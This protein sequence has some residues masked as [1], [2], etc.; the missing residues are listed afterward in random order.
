MPEGIKSTVRL[1][2]DDTIVY[3]TI[4]SDK[5]STDLQEDLDRLAKWETVW[6]ILFH[7]QKCNVLTISRKTTPIK[8][9]YKLH[10]HTLTSV[11]EAKYLGITFTEDL[12]WNQHITNICSKAN[13]ML[14]FLKRN[15][16][17]SAKSVKE[18]ACRSLVRPLVEY[19]SPVWD[20]YNQ[21][22]IQKIEMVQRRGAR[23]VNNKHSSLTSVDSMMEDLKWR[24]LE[25]RR[26]DARLILM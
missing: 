12:R 5:D 8:T 13:R 7:P 4:A 6:K 16:N 17:I 11:E 2:A 3:L 10:S 14:G 21:N 26:R 15:L 23:Y 24:S 20:P 1:F 9:S 18:N 22:N 25:D 19:A